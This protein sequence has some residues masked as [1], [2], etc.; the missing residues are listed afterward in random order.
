MEYRD[1]E[2]AL[3]GLAR[4]LADAYEEAQTADDRE[5]AAGEIAGFINESGEDA[6]DD[7]L[8]ALLDLP[9]SNVT[10]TW[11]IDRVEALLTARGP[12]AVEAL[13]VASRGHVYDIAGPSPRRALETLSAM[14]DT[15]VDEVVQGLIEVLSGSGDQGLKDAAAAGLVAIGPP[16]IDQLRRARTDPVAAQ[17]VEDAL[18][19]LRAS[20]PGVSTAQ[21]AEAADEEP[22]SEPS[23]GDDASDEPAGEV[24]PSEDEAA[25]G[26]GVDDPACSD[27]E[28]SESD[29]EDGLAEE[30]AGETGRDATGVGMPD[31]VPELPDSAE[32]DRRYHVFA[33]SIDGAIDQAPGQ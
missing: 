8:I 15:E 7:A 20:S 21:D 19:E 25:A 32:L 1:Q 31:E 22:E 28:A 18:G 14:V 13:L 11:I 4:Q 12:G 2:E 17:W 30:A 29:A 9:R 6:P 16:A 24:V 10:T 33:D 5:Y 23:S 27:G 3:I 26:L